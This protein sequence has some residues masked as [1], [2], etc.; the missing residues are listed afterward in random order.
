MSTYID[1]LLTAVSAALEINAA[2]LSG[3][4]DVVVIRQA[5]GSL[6][7]TP[8]HVRFGKLQLLRSREKVVEIAVEAVEEE[9]KEARAQRKASDGLPGTLPALPPPT[10]IDTGAVANKVPL[11]MLLGAAGEAFFVEEAE[12]EMELANDS[13]QRE[14][15]WVERAPSEPPSPYAS[16]SESSV[17]GG[18]TDMAAFS[19]GEQAPPINAVRSGTADAAGSRTPPL[20]SS[21]GSMFSG[22]LRR[23]SSKDWTTGA[24]PGQ[25]GQHGE[26]ASAAPDLESGT[27]ER[28]RHRPPSSAHDR[29]ARHV[30]ATEV[31][32]GAHEPMP[33]DMDDASDTH[34]SNVSEEAHP[35]R[36]R[37]EGA[38]RG[39]QAGCGPVGL[40]LCAHLIGPHLTEQQVYEIFEANRVTE[41]QFQRN[42]NVLHHPDLLV[43][44]DDRLYPYRI[45][46]PMLMGALAFGTLL[47]AHTIDRRM[48][49]P[50]QPQSPT[51]ATWSSASKS[52]P[53]RARFTWFGLRSSNLDDTSGDEA[54][55][56][57]PLTGDAEASAPPPPISSAPV[58]TV[59]AATA[60]ATA[61]LSP[62]PPPLP[63]RQPRYV[64]KSLYPTSAQ[65]QQLGLRPGTNRITFTVRSRLQGVQQVGCRIYLWPH[66]VKICVS[67]VD[68]TITRSDLLGQILPRVG[69]DWSQ[70]GVASLYRAIVRNGYQFLYLTSRAIGQATSTRAYLTTLLQDG[71]LGLPDGPVLMSPDRFFESF[72]REVIYRRPQDFKIVALEQVRCLFP[73][74]GYN[75]FFAGFGNRDTDREAYGAVGIPR[76][77]V[78]LVNSR[79]ELQ[80][81]HSVYASLASY[82]ALQE[83]VDSL[84]PDIR[85][86]FGHTAIN[87]VTDE[88]EYND[89]N[90]WKRPYSPLHSC[91]TSPESS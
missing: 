58:E 36:H 31:P 86:A 8:F 69:K 20:G 67:D 47:D 18:V 26:V 90:Y 12:S 13:L 45:A 70:R 63:L 11:T 29:D 7:S 53:P 16:P 49:R 87:R 66:D 64:R 76:E 15:L 54:V 32:L 46:A 35:A 72:S 34:L 60:T 33:F 6:R 75:P 79:G 78:F 57:E 1:R 71:G 38:R 41:E 10:G 23:R 74:N 40:S 50:Q 4:V 14:A 89:F 68:G 65:L 80:V 82:H 19:D 51:G 27:A 91:S 73:H 17:A 25:N 62:D 44:V 61:T 84:F 52:R 24:V 88:R 28:Q 37:G 30:S 83:L 5:D 21:W 9:G 55:M 2:T 81:G 3:A 85:H 43:L 77:R 48:Q 22:V 56:G 39:R 42:P 59:P